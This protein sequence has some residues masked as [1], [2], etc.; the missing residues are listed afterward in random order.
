MFRLF[1]DWRSRPLKASCLVW[2]A[3]AILS[4]A[5]AAAGPLDCTTNYEIREQFSN[6]AEWEMCWELRNREGIVLSDI[7]YTTPDGTRRKV[8]YQASV[9]QIHVPYDDDGAR[10]HDVS[11]YGL[12][13][14]SNLNNLKAA[15]CP[16]GTRL[17]E[18][19]KSVI[20][21]TTETNVLSTVTADFARQGE[22]LSLFSVSHVGAYN[23]IPN[24][25]F[26]DDGTIDIGMGATGKLQRYGPSSDSE[27]GWRINQSSNPIGISHLHNYF[28]R[29]DFDLADG[30]DDDVVEEIEFRAE[31]STGRTREK[32]VTPFLAEASS[33]VNNAR[34]RFWRVKDKDTFNGEG[35]EISYD[36]LPLETGHK[37]TGPSFEPFTFNDIYI[38]RQRTCEKYASHNPSDGGSCS[39]NEDLSD[40]VDGETLVNR[41][42]VVWFGITFH[43]VPRDE[44]ESFMNAHWNR[45]QLAPRDWIEG[46][47]A[48]GNNPPQLV[49]PGNQTGNVED[50]VSLQLQASDPDGDALTYSAS[51]LPASLSINSTT[52]LIS[53]TLQGEGSYSVTVYVHDESA[54]SD[55]KSFTWTVG[56]RPN[57]N[58]W[59]THPGPQSNYAGDV[60]DLQIVAGDPDGDTL[61]YIASQCAP[62]LSLGFFDGRF[63]GQL[64][65]AG[66]Y[67][68]KFVVSDGRGGTYDTEFAWFVAA[69]TSNVAPIVTNPGPQESY[70]G[71]SVTLNIEAIDVNTTDVLIYSAASLPDG[72]SIDPSSGVISGVLASANTWAVTVTVDDQVGGLSQVAFDWQ[73]TE[74]LT[75]NVGPLGRGL[76][77]RD[78]ATGQGYAMYTA[79]RIQTRFSSPPIDPLSADHIVIVRYSG[80]NWQYVT[81]SAFVNFAPRSDDLIIAAVDFSADT[82]D[83]LVGND[84]MINGIRAGYIESDVVITP[85][86][87]NGSYN[88]GE[89][90]MTGTYILAHAGDPPLPNTPPV[91]SSPGNQLDSVGGT[92][93]LQLAASD[94]DFDPLTYSASGLP[95]NLAINSS[96]GRITGSLTTFGTYTVS[97]SVSDGNG[98]L[99]T[100][101]I[102]WYVSPAAGTTINIGPLGLGITGKDNATGSGYAMYTNERIQTRFTS[103][104]IDPASADHVLA[105]RYSGGNWQ[106]IT[107]NEFVNFVP[108]AT[109]LLVAEL[110]FSADTVNMLNGT[111]SVVNGMKSGYATGDIV[112]TP[113]IWNGST[114]AGEFGITGTSIVTN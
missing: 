92:V 50:A 83:Q 56:P 90:G 102:I 74:G 95:A 91:L 81:D 85:N 20:C 31:D 26:F 71:D 89:F 82:V 11:D 36:I 86:Q 12:G 63:T 28:W 41:D 14:S 47:P 113:N 59:V 13:T 33:S 99:D 57:S 72:L 78:S 112:I 44:D 27:Y 29:L 103:P 18:G 111:S 24:W 66:A 19:T 15:D 100:E 37:D 52:G 10:Y 54:A 32:Y 40:F 107:D 39:A 84:V 76:T 114:N 96:T 97:L 35:A 105:V 62:G 42:L 53:G 30:V 2:L 22:S 25:T 101:Q 9:A 75:L 49:S 23:Y 87:W 7:H 108:R 106:Y 5:T 16:N 1:A 94:A 60:V 88:A 6:G 43:H 110:D 98:G 45:F 4:P 65:A 77:G 51:N 17:T 58:P 68:C 64:Q 69:P 34:Q 55:S 93:D 21:R 8:L 104:A 48:A 3:A 109:D 73:V 38:T 61:N 67:S 79:E 46:T 80:S 70:L